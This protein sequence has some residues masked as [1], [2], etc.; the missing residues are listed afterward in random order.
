[1]ISYNI[2]FPLRDDTEKGFFLKMNNI[3]KDAF[4]SDLLLLL[5]TEKGQKWYDPAYGSFLI[6]FL[7][8]PNDTLLQDDIIK[9]MKETVSQYIPQLTISN[10]NFNKLKSDN[11]DV[12]E[13]GIN[14]HIDF[15]YKE[16]VFEE[17]GEIDL[18][19]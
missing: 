17:Q 3:T 14:V 6:K 11:L 5:L 1:M 2:K 4:A 10:V 8:E 15:V 13:H 19:F 7:F 9:D 18:N 12:T 16:G